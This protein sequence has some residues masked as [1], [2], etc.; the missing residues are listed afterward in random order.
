MTDLR[1]DEEFLE[2]ELNINLLGEITEKFQNS[3]LQKR[4]NIL[5]KSYNL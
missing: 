4:I 3:T 5:L 2:N 1:L